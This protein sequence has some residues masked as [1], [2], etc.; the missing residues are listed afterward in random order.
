M[1]VKYTISV[2]AGDRAAHSCRQQVYREQSIMNGRICS[3]K[4]CSTKLSFEPQR[5]PNHCSYFSSCTTLQLTLAYAYS[6]ILPSQ[7]QLHAL[8]P[9]ALFIWKVSTDYHISVQGGLS[10]KCWLK[11]DGVYLYQSSSIFWLQVTWKVS[12]VV[13]ENSHKV[14]LLHRG[15]Q[16]QHGYVLMHLIPQEITLQFL[17]KSLVRECNCLCVSHRNGIKYMLSHIR[18][19]SEIVNCA[20]LVTDHNWVFM[21]CKYNTCW[22]SDS[23]F[24]ICG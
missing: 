21:V 1:S 3:V 19:L 5:R 2:S 17:Y 7:C 23:A 9:V 4:A 6:I 16:G 15:T 13:D 12:W 24:Q 10:H 14:M 11:R 18:E 8:C 20:H 22:Y